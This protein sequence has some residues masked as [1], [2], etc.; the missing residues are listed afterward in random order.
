MYRIM[1]SVEGSRKSRSIGAEPDTIELLD[2]IEGKSQ[3]G[4]LR[5]GVA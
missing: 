3:S 4:R 2:K 5:A 1:Y